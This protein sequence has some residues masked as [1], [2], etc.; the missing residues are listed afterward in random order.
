[1][2]RD[3]QSDQPTSYASNFQISEEDRMNDKLAGP[4]PDLHQ[5]VALIGAALELKYGTIDQLLTMT[6]NQEDIVADKIKEIDQQV[7]R[8]KEQ[9]AKLENMLNTMNELL[10]K[11][12]AAIGSDQNGAAC[13][14]SDP[15]N[16]EFFRLWDE[17]LLVVGDWQQLSKSF[18][19]KEKAAFVERMLSII[20]QLNLYQLGLSAVYPRSTA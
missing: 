17:P 6:T 18:T 1:M 13:S 11:L 9:M 8:L 16:V 12:I 20:E 10:P 5:S 4:N 2:D 15:R 7:S 3:R 14:D 19:E